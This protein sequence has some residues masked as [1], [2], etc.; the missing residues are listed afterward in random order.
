MSSIIAISISLIAVA[1]C[2]VLGFAD[3]PFLFIL[4]FPIALLVVFSTFLFLITNL[5]WWLS[6]QSIKN[7]YQTQK[8]RFKA[9][10]M[11]SLVFIFLGGWIINQ[12]Y[13]PELLHP[14]SLLGNVGI[15]IFTL[16]LAWCLLKP[17]KKGNLFVWTLVFIS[18]IIF[19]TAFAPST[20]DKIDPSSN[21]ALSLYHI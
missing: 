1:I 9:A 5:I 11:T 13:L 7:T 10:I 8:T 12:R 21:N 15:L 18:F 20:V 4:F 14:I 3:C 16:F 19:L 6:P 2:Y 17:I